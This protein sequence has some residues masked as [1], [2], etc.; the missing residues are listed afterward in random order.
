MFSH[1]WCNVIIPVQEIDDKA[2][3]L[4]CLVKDFYVDFSSV[5]LD[6]LTWS[7]Q[8]TL[9]NRCLNEIFGGYLKCP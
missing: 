8:L 6:Q 1:S 4:F 5:E 7:K 2:D 9:S 3:V